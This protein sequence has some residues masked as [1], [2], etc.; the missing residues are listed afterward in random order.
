MQQSD[1]LWQMRR[2]KGY[3]MCVRVCESVCVS[4]RGESNV[5]LSLIRALAMRL[6]PIFPST[7]CAKRRV[8]VI[9]APSGLLRAH[10]CV[11]LC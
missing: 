5:Q 1:R 6:S 9:Q 3:R 2:C 7:I 10:D 8:L 4:V 11:C